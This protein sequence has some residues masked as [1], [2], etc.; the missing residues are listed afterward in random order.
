MPRSPLIFVAED[1][2]AIRELVRARLELAGYQTAAT[3]DGVEALRICSA[4]RPDA[5]VLDINL[6]GL[7]GFEVLAGLRKAFPTRPVPVL[8]LTARHA[9]D[10]VARAIQAGA[11]DYLT[12][13]FHDAQLLFRVA[14]LLKAPQ[15]VAPPVKTVGLD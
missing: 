11:N 5:A 1:D 3:A 7:N 10:D 9:S 12:K 2:A 8:M 4:Q 14:R 13:P 15:P 6:P